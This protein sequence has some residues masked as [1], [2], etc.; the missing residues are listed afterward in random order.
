METKKTKLNSENDYVDKIIDNIIDL[1]DEIKFVD[2]F[3]KKAFPDVINLQIEQLVKIF[4]CSIK[5][6]A[7]YAGIGK[8]KELNETEKHL[9]EHVINGLTEYYIKQM[10]NTC[11]SV[12][13]KER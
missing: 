2:E 11:N 10:I 13:T 5:Q 3:L 8:M 9:R 1:A 6:I 4:E 7:T 12:K